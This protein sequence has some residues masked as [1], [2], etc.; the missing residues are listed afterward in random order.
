MRL[1]IAFQVWTPRGG[2]WRQSVVDFSDDETIQRM[3]GD[4]MQDGQP[5]PIFDL[6]FVRGQFPT[7]GHPA[8]EDS[9]ETDPDWSRLATAAERIAGV[10]E[11]LEEAD[12]ASREAGKA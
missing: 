2:S 6:D 9:V 10:M 1:S 12:K 4:M 11:R 8:H 7:V 3:R 5:V